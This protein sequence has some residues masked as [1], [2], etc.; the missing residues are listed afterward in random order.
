[1]SDNGPSDSKPEA[2]GAGGSKGKEPRIAQHSA[3]PGI[4]RPQTPVESG[5][6]APRIPQT[7][8]SR[9]LRKK[10]DAAK[11]EPPPSRVRRILSIPL[12]YLSAS[13]A[14]IL[15]IFMAVGYLATGYRDF[16]TVSVVAAILILANGWSGLVPAPTKHTSAV[17]ATTVGVLAV[18]AVRI[19]D[20]MAWATISLGVA[21]LVAA[22]AEM[23]RPLPRENLVQSISASTAAAVTAVLGSAWVGLATSKLWSAVLVGSAVVVT[24]AV[25]GNQIGKSAK[26][27]TI[28]ALT[29]GSLSGLAMGL[30][31]QY[32]GAELHLIQYAFPTLAGTFSP[33]VAVVIVS[34][35][36]GFAIG[37]TIALVDIVFGEHVRRCTEA[38]A[39]ARGA[40]KFLLV[41]MPIYVI[42]RIGGF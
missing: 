33:Y 5:Q 18:L 22:I 1:M 21:V 27:N 42:V 2:S 28:G 41:V 20:D 19:T 34:T 3:T 39:L 36:M 26:A 6:S 11:V 30:L 32:L 15:S 24:F 14:A 31:A 16:V 29:L 40:M 23:A 37:M 17:T 9:S 25:I 10:R 4:S 8:L 12:S 38:G 13:V 7:R 35:V